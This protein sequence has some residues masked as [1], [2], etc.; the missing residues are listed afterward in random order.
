[1][2]V[3]LAPLTL[4]ERPVFTSAIVADY[5]DSLVGRGEDGPGSRQRS[6]LPFRPGSSSG[7]RTMPKAPRSG[8]C[9][10]SAPWKGCRPLRPSYT[11]SLSS[12]RSGAK[13]TAPPCW[14]HW[15]TFWLRTAGVSCAST[16]GTPMRRAGACTSGLGTNWSSGSRPSASYTSDCHPP[17]PTDLMPAEERA[18]LPS[19]RPLTVGLILIPSPSTPQS[20]GR[21]S[22]Q[23]PPAGDSPAP[24]RSANA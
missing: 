16:S 6:R 7:P 3:V 18:S 15:R 23:W 20:T 11:R 10:L 19:S 2:L 12:R 22:R 14:P 9:G 17:T 5:V 8:G 13:A 1:M 21:D 24:A 4:D